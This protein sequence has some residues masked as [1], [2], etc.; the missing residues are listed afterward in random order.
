MANGVRYERRFNTVLIQSLK[1]L[2]CEGHKLQH[3][4]RPLRG[5]KPFLLLGKAASRKSPRANRAASL[6]D[7]IIS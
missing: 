3:F 4:S 7:S 2:F 6:G 5:L 1:Q